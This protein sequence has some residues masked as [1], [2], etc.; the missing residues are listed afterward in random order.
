LPRALEASEKALDLD[1]LD[2]DI[3]LVNAAISAAV[4]PARRDAPIRAVR[5]AIAIDSLNAHAWIELGIHQEE[6]DQMDSALAS[7]R[8]GMALGKRTVGT[9]SYANY[10]YW[11]R[12]F[13]SAAVWSDSAIKY[14]PWLPY[15]RELAGATAI[16]RKRYDDAQTHYEAAFRLDQGR[17]RVRSLEGLAELAALRGKTDSAL[18]FIADAEKLTD[19]SAPSDHEAI[20]IASAYAA[21]GKRE[22]ALQWLERYQPRANLHFQLH[23]RYDAQLDPLRKDPRFAAILKE[24]MSTGAKR[25]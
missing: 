1:S 8:R 7:L 23:V 5:R 24:S 16:M 19:A 10:F 11:Q 3:W 18:K 6:L 9:A 21:A 14:S 17:T 12:E 15:A 25:E 20:A 13:D 22:K 4:D 2:A